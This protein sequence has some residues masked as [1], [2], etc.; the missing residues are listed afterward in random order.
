MIVDELR[1]C[2]SLSKQRLGPSRI[3]KW[4]ETDSDAARDSETIGAGECESGR[5]GS[6]TREAPPLLSGLLGE[7]D[8]SLFAVRRILQ[9]TGR[10]IRIAAGRASRNDDLSWPGLIIVAGPT[11]RSGSVLGSTSFGGLRKPEPVSTM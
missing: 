1:F 10:R 5:P 9:E 3:R 7:L 4:E 6:A 2:R 11:L 8:L